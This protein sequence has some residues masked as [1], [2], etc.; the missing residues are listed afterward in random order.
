MQS[1][2]LVGTHAI[3]T[4]LSCTKELKLGWI[5]N[6]VI[7]WIGGQKPMQINL[8]WSPTK[9]NPHW[10]IKTNEIDFIGAPNQFNQ[11]HWCLP[12]PMHSNSL[13]L[14]HTDSND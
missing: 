8:G 1:Y 2:S 14:T 4:C 13:V 9:A 7:F 11:F 5:F 10:V 12:T 3:K 6:Q